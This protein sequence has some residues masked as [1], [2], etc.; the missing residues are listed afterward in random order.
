M[1]LPEQEYRYNLE[2]FGRLS[3]SKTP[4]EMYI[5]PGEPHIKFQPR[6]KL[7]VYE[8]NLAWFERWLLADP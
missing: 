8:R 5:Y 1:Q 3:A 2:L 4:V 6:H 7:A